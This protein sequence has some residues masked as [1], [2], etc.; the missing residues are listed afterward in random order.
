MCWYMKVTHYRQDACCQ[1]DIPKPCTACMQQPLGQ[2][3]HTAWLCRRRPSVSISVTIT[4]L[5]A[6]G[7]STVSQTVPT[8]PDHY[9]RQ[10]SQ[11]APDTSLLHDCTHVAHMHTYIHTDTHT[12]THTKAYTHIAGPYSQHCNSAAVCPHL[13]RARYRIMLR[14]H[15]LPMQ[16]D[17]LYGLF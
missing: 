13:L 6:K 10:W 16:Q 5:Q 17:L 7:F 14:Y 4:R 9:H 3:K 12:H 8:L 1:C 11:A 15:C 2:A